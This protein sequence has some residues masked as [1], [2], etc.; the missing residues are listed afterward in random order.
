VRRRTFWTT[1]GFGVLLAAA[2]CLFLITHWAEK[3]PS[4]DPPAPRVP[5]TTAIVEMNDVPIELEA[6]GRVTALKMVSVQSLVGG[7]IVANK[8]KDGQYVHQGDVLVEIDPRPLQ[9]TVNQDKA[10]LARDRASLT[11]AE[12]DLKRYIPLVGNGVVS[13]QQVTTQRSVVAQLQGTVAA[14][15][16]LLERAQ[17]QL[18]YTSINAP[19]SGVLGLTLVDPGNIITQNNPT[20][21]VVLTQIQPI[22]VQ[23]PLPQAVLP[24]VQAGRAASGGLSAEAWSADGSRLL[25]KGKVIAL[26]NQVDPTSG[27]FTLK[28]VFPNSK[29]ALWPGASVVV[30][31]VLDVQHDGLTVP[32]TAVNEGP[33]GSYAWVIGSDETARVVPIKLRQQLRGTALVSSGLTG[34]EK[35]VTNGQHASSRAPMSPPR[36]LRPLRAAAHCSTPISRDNWESRNDERRGRRRRGPGR[37]R[38]PAERRA[39]RRTRWFLGVFHPATRVHVHADGWHRD[40]R[41]RCLLRPSRRV[42]PHGRRRDDPGHGR[43][44]GRRPADQRLRRHQPLGE[45]VRPY[46]RADPDDFGERQQLRRDHPSVRLQAQ[47]RQRRDSR[48]GGDHGRRRLPSQHADAAPDLPGDEPGRHAGAHPRPDVGHAPADTWSTTTARTFCSSTCPR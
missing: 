9:A 41:R 43:A 21:S 31:L 18:G 33:D 28:A 6:I 20:T 16:A 2:V 30:R 48:A 35:V 27:T 47:G 23:F 38:R 29:Q 46:L 1:P 14:D 8:F 25:D 5:V 15:E 44:V 40:G 26:N 3:K 7:Q 22:A 39:G 11:N 13:V 4:P 12:T 42:P 32:S 10:N 19:I 24:E 37:P 36:R 45:T 17:V 34:G